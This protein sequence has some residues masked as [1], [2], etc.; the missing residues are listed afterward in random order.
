MSR[1]ETWTTRRDVLRRGGGG[2]AL[3]S[4]GSLAGCLGGGGE[5]RVAMTDSF[6]FEPETVAV[7]PGSTVVWVNDGFMPHTVTAY[8]SRLPAG[9]AFFASGGFET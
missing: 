7:S 9:A 6:A 2:A 8:E 5:T 3:L 1:R 4:L